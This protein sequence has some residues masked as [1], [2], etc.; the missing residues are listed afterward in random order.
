MAHFLALEGS[1][2]KRSHQ[3][4]IVPVHGLESM[5]NCAEMTMSFKMVDGE[6]KAYHRAMDYIHRPTAFEN[7]CVY[8]F[9]EH[10]EVVKKQ[11]LDKEK[12]YFDLH[13][14]HPLKGTHVAVYRERK[15]VPTFGWRIP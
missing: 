2:F 8:Y 3:H 15:A 4:S 9:Y 10:V 7:M 14:D 6:T 13:D 11:Y 1:R 12:E 5:L